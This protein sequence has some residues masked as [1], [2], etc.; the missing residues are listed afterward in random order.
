MMLVMHIGQL[1]I[2]IL[3]HR[4]A[5]TCYFL[6]F[7]KQRTAY[8][9][10]ISDLSSDVCS[11]DLD[12]WAAHLGPRPEEPV[13][14]DDPDNYAEAMAQ[15]STAVALFNAALEIGRASC[16]ERECQYV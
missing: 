8:E 11:S 6:F 10:R 15:Y 9:L 14:A 16:R 5:L 1:A 7:F 13:E 2:V 12:T 4:V 3:D